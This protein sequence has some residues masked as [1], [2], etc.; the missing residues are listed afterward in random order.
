[1]KFCKSLH[2]PV[3]KAQN[4]NDY[5]IYN[6]STGALYFDRDGSRSGAQVQIAT[7]SNKAALGASDISIVAS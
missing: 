1:M 6:R 2:K 3:S 7:L 5:F 4:Y